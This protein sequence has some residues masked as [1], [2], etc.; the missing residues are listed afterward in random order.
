MTEEEK[1]HYSADRN[2]WCIVKYAGATPVYYAG[3]YGKYNGQENV[4]PAFTTDFNQA[5]KL[6]SKIAAEQLFASLKRHAVN[7]FSECN[8][9]DHRW[10]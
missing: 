4:L 10:M 1:D 9:E 5:L 3:Y 6:H 2:H 7:N 8:V